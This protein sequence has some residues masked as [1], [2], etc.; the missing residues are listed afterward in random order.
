MRKAGRS[1]LALI[2]AAG[3]VSGC[4]WH[5]RPSEPAWRNQVRYGGGPSVGPPISSFTGQ[6]PP[7][8]WCLRSA[9]RATGDLGGNWLQTSRGWLRQVLSDSSELGAW[10]KVL[11]GAPV[12]VA[13]D[14]ITQVLDEVTCRE[15]AQMLNRDLLGW[16]VGPPPVVVFR[17]RDFLIA[18]PSNARRGEF[19]M[20]AG[21]GLDH[22][23]RGVAAW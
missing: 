15:I 10:H 1:V 6:A 3:L 4:A 22:R 19:G 9:G 11:G 14:S 18:F 20:A 7:T 12:L 13:T 23:I 5:R 2:T 17:I 8:E 21:M 16:E